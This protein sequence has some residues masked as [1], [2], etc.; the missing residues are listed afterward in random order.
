MV[1]KILFALIISS[2]AVFADPAPFGLQI[3]KATVSTLKSKYSVQY[4]GI[5]K[6][7]QG[8]MYE[9]EASS[10]SFDGLESAT[11]VFGASGT[12]QAV[13]CTLP[14]DKFQYLYGSLKKKYKLLSSNI[15]FVG[16]SS[17]KFVDGNTEIVLNAPHMSFE[18][19]MNYIDKGLLVKF[20]Q[21][22]SHEVEQ[23]KSRESSQL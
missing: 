11:A 15:P 14:K 13:L 12:L 23:K 19:D 17:A 16:D 20:K 4:K 8:E 5:N 10:L 7:S 2:A 3:G 21:Q 1:F 9:I 22:S 18:M 6:Y